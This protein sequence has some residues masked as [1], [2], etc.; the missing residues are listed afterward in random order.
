VEYALA[1]LI[2]EGDARLTE[3]SALYQKAAALKP[4]D[5]REYLDIAIA[6]NGL[7]S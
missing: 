3:A 1:L 2:L 7:T 5:A 4:T 6:R